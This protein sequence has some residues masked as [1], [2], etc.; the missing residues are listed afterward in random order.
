MI[1]ESKSEMKMIESILLVKID[2]EIRINKIYGVHMFL[3]LKNEH[4][5]FLKIFYFTH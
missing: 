4:C 3:R 5:S 1:R 2:G